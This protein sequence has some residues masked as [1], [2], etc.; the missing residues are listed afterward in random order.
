MRHWDKMIMAVS[1]LLFHITQSIFHAPGQKTYRNIFKTKIFLIVY[2]MAAIL[3]FPSTC[4]KDLR[5][6][7]QSHDLIFPKTRKCL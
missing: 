2:A 1:C 6:C 7:D 4:S 5:S 3:L